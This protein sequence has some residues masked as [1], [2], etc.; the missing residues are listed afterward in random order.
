MAS[1][2]RLLAEIVAQLLDVDEAG[3]HPDLPVTDIEAGARAID[4][5][6]PVHT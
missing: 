1:D 6:S 4:R 5:R 2:D 3:L